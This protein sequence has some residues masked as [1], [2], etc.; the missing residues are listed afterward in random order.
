MWKG[1]RSCGASSS[2]NN[3]FPT[4]SHPKFTEREIISEIW[5]KIFLQLGAASNFLEHGMNMDCSHS[6]LTSKYFRSKENVDLY[7]HSPHTS[8][9]R[10]A[11]W[12]WNRDISAPSIAIV[13]D[14]ILSDVNTEADCG[15][16]HLDVNL[17]NF[18]VTGR[19]G[20]QGCEMLRIPHCLDNR[21]TVNC[22]ILATCSSTYSPV[23][24]SQEEH[25][26]SIK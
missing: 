9:W 5:G 26:V 16:E 6:S 18:P 11:Q 17:G 8:S 21:L 2:P 1:L 15:L 4:C 22:E 19:G 20:L 12:C 14:F 24:T 10:S 3:L 13:L 7:S 25:S 23:C